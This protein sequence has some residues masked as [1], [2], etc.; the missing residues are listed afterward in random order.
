VAV[1]FALQSELKIAKPTGAVGEQTLVNANSELKNLTKI[2][3]KLLAI[4]RCA[5]IF[6]GYLPNELNKDYGMRDDIAERS[7]TDHLGVAA[8][9]FSR[10]K[11]IGALFKPVY[12]GLDT[13]QKGSQ[14]VLKVQQWLNRVY[15]SDSSTSY[16]VPNGVRSAEIMFILRAYYFEQVGVSNSINMGV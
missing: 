14:Q 8:E 3:M 11:W 6:K 16:L 15:G 5:L 7:F 1:T 13:F 12:I 2:P 9:D 10:A 4:V